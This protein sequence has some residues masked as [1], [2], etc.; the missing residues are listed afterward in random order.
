MTHEQRRWFV[1]I[2][3]AS[4]E[5]VV[6]L[7]DRQGKKIGQR[8]FAH[9][10]T[11]LSDMIAWL[12]KA[13]GGRAGEIHV[14]IE[15][16]HGPIVEGLLER[17]F[18]VYSI[19][20]KQLDRFRDRFTVSGAKDDSLDAYVLADSLRTDMPLFR[21]LSIAEPLIVE[22]REWSRIDENLKTERLRL[23]NRLRHQL[24]R[25]YPQMLEIADDLAHGWIL[26][27]WELAPTPE[28]AA[29]MREATVARILKSYRIRRFDATHV[30]TELRKPALNVA[31]G[32]TEASTAHIRVL[33]EQLRLVNRQ[34]AQAE[35][36]LD[37][38]CKKL[39]EPVGGE[40][41]ENVPGQRQEHRDVTILDSLPGVGRIVLVTMLAE[42]PD[43]LRRRDYHA[44]RNLCGSA[45]VTR[46]SGKSR[47]VLRR[48]ACNRRL[49]SAAFNWRR[50]AIQNDPTSCAKYDALRARGHGHAR[51]I[52]SVVD[53]LLYIACAML[54]SRT[55]FDPS[56]SG[57]KNAVA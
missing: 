3:W 11:G 32:T 37:R 25:Y 28:K 49:T 15:T 42:A 24:W 4:Q 22:L 1:G 20:P 2:D 9:G 6:S 8:N 29:R 50:T 10:G 19:N 36:Q 34:L 18:N 38:L 44:L 16:P 45:P 54:E 33:I 57:K 55:L 43:A 23:A 12:L 14:A 26:D 17:D 52:R 46:R 31:Q 30:I 40:Q 21:K 7:C 48:R 51:A 47:I 5:H 56:L 53:R 41:G 13:S 39:A 27:L 35:R